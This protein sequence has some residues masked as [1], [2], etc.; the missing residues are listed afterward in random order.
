MQ[1]QATY[2][3]IFKLDF[4]LLG[5]YCTAGTDTQFLEN[6]ATRQDYNSYGD[7]MHTIS[8]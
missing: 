2:T 6:I 7:T 1:I 8:P 3:F 4:Y 5:G